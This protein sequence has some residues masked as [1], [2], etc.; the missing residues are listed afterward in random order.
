VK[1][2]PLATWKFNAMKKATKA[3]KG[4][5]R[6]ATSATPDVISPSGTSRANIAE[7]GIATRPRYR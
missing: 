3:K 7:W 4:V 6:P 1:R 5:Q 2:A